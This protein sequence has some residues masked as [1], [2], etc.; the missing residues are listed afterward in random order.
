M[1]SSAV[2][3]KVM[4]RVILDIG[5]TMP[6]QFASKSLSLTDSH[7]IVQNLLRRESL[8]ISVKEKAS[9]ESSMVSGSGPEVPVPV[10]CSSCKA[11]AAMTRRPL[12]VSR[13]WPSKPDCRTLLPW[14]RTS[15]AT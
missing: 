2:G 6:P 1:A 11:Q 10:R 14:V 3:E 5:R 15:M 8:R 12:A 4:K 9:A 13:G 7:K